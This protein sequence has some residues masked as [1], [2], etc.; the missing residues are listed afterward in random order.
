MNAG[1]AMFISVNAAATTIAG[2]GAL[3]VTNVIKMSTDAG[4][5][6]LLV[7]SLVVILSVALS[8]LMC[9]YYYIKRRF[10]L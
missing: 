8:C 2:F 5:T 6:M 4:W 10:K 1:E 9:G 7:G 3:G